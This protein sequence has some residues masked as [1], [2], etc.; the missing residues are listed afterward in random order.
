MQA[1]LSSRLLPDHLG[2]KQPADVR[3]KSVATALL[4]FILAVMAGVII[5]LLGIETTA[6]GAL[7]T[8]TSIMTGLTFTMAMRFWERSIDA[9][10]DPDVV[11]NT[12]RLNTLD[13]MRTTL[14][15]TVLAGLI[16]TAWLAGA[17]LVI[18]SNF[19][20]AWVSGVSAAFVTYQLSYVLR[21]LLAL[22]AASYTLR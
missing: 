20:A 16:S 1:K 3:N 8:A 18:G 12:E 13:S 2:L 9:R 11:F 4:C 5:W 21:S 19:S 17:A 15:W 7:L 6:L 14:L 22:Y 10:S